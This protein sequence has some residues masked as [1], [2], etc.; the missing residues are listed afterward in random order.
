M[1]WTTVS[2]QTE[3]LEN[4][5]CCIDV[6]RVSFTFW[7]NQQKNWTFSV[8]FWVFWDQQWNQKPQLPQQTHPTCP[9][10]PWPRL[11]PLNPVTAEL[12]LQGWIRTSQQ[13]CFHTNSPEFYPFV[14]T[15]LMSFFALCEEA[16]TARYWMTFLVFSVFPA[17]DSPLQEE[18]NRVTN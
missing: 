16:M 12:M 1:V 10:S 3:C 9:A 4:K 14:L 2:T 18:Q 13:W 8:M 17:P 11:Q 7:I 15:G 6:D 5:I